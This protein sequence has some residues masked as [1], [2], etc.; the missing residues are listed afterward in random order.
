[1][2]QIIVLISIIAVAGVCNSQS[3]TKYNNLNMEEA[4]ELGNRI[5]EEYIVTSL[6]K[7]QSNKNRLLLS[8]F[9]TKI[10]ESKIEKEPVIKIKYKLK[11][12]SKQKYVYDC[13][14]SVTVYYD[15]NK[16][17]IKETIQID[18]KY[19]IKII[20]YYFGREKNVTLITPLYILSK[21]GD[22]NGNFIADKNFLTQK[23]SD[24]ISAFLKEFPLADLEKEY[25][26]KG[27]K[28]GIHIKFIFTVEG[29]NKEIYISNRYQKDLGK[30]TAL[31]SKFLREDYLMYSEDYFNY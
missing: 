26:N 21:R 14:F 8:D 3:N 1:M 20:N 10:K 12:E 25:I 6:N 17:K 28:D 18:S 19:E 11:K 24:E 16:L 27:V 7:Y 13:D 9:E 4:V 22:T 30:L 5:A 23:Q 31:I 15:K 29:N 2:K